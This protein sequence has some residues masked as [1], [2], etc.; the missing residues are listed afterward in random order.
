M[1]PPDTWA[2]M[3]GACYVFLRLASSKRLTASCEMP[4]TERLLIA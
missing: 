1:Q 3:A 4:S 2:D